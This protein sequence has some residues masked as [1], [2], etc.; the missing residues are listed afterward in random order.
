M[1]Y[2]VVSLVNFKPRLLFAVVCQ[3]HQSLWN[4]FTIWS[5]IAC[6]WNTRGALVL[7]CKSHLLQ[8]RISHT[9][10]CLFQEKSV[11]LKRPHFQAKLLAHFRR[12]SRSPKDRFQNKNFERC[13]EWGQDFQGRFDRLQLWCLFVVDSHNWSS[14]LLLNARL[15]DQLSDPCS[16]SFL[17]YP[18]CTE[19]WQAWD[20]SLGGPWA[21]TLYCSNQKSCVS[22]CVGPPAWSAIT[23]M[24]ASARLSPRRRKEKWIH[25]V[26]YWIEFGRESLA[27]L[28]KH[29]SLILRKTSASFL[30]V[31]LTV[32]FNLTFT[33]IIE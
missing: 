27:W 7:P 4:S 23:R 2:Q 21:Q 11:G 8:A 29:T 9:C 26:P 10:R 32:W 33:L 6:P 14:Q 31:F 19:Q 28:V 12:G 1:T 30:F 20:S 18:F 5:W 16:S 17:A 25:H 15:A 13:S 22:I 3:Y 24:T